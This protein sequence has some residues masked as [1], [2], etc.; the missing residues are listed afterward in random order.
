[1]KKTCLATCPTDRYYLS[2]TKECEPCPYGCKTCTASNNCTACYTSLTFDAATNKC[3]CD[4]TNGSFSL[5][6]LG[7]VLC[8]NCSNGC[9]VCSNEKECTTCKTS[10]RLNKFTKG[11]ELLPE[12]GLNSNI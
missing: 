12:S 7:R 8:V 6:E 5:S 11:C 1:M 2:A 3:Y 10:H 9:A 4:N